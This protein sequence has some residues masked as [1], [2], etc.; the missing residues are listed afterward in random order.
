[1]KLDIAAHDGDHL[2]DGTVICRLKGPVLGILSGERTALNFLQRLS[3]I[4]TLS[5]RYAS[6]IAHT[7]AHLLDTRKTTPGLRLLEKAAVRHG[8]GLN[9]RIGLYDMVLIKDT[10]IK[11]AGGVAAAIRK[12]MEWRGDHNTVKIEVEVQSIEECV[13]ALALGPDRIMLDNMCLDDMRRCV[14]MTRQSG[15]KIELEAS[16][17]ITLETI[18]SVAETGVD[19]ISCGALTH[20]APSID[21]HLVIE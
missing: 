21:I 15:A 10:H 13:E 14:E 4:A 5:A 16:G 11:R 8:G 9:H 3:G 19:F 1:M 7:G 6:A 2:V 17:G 20:S 18:G 12:A